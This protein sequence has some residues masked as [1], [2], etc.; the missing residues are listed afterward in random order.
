MSRVLLPIYRET[1]HVSPPL[2]P[3]LSAEYGP[4]VLLHNEDSEQ[5]TL[6]I[7]D[8]RNEP[9]FEILVEETQDMWYH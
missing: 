2:C 3:E 7:K 9:K 6:F 8:A 4:D 5:Y 1:W